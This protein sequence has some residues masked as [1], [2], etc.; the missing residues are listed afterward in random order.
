MDCFTCIYGTGAASVNSHPH[1]SSTTTFYM[2]HECTSLALFRPHMLRVSLSTGSC[3][4]SRR[5]LSTPRGERRHSILM[6][7]APVYYS[8]TPCDGIVQPLVKSRSLSLHQSSHVDNRYRH[9][10]HV[11][12][13]IEVLL[14]LATLPSGG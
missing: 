2:L 4:P 7:S 3:R 11:E 14:V 9:L 12:A 6:H 1:R 10:G 8:N 13:G 5:D